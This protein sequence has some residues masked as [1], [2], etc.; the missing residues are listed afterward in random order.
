M[1]IKYYFLLIVK[2]YKNQL[3]PIVGGKVRGVEEQII[4]S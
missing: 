4:C 1:P 3:Q 2:N